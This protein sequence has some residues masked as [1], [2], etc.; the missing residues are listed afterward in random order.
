MEWQNKFETEKKRA[1]KVFGEI[2][3]GEDLANFE[4]EFLGK[5]SVLSLCNKNIKNLAPSEKQKWGREL[6]EFRQNWQQK[7][8]EKK[9]EIGSQSSDL[10]GGEWIDVSKNFPSRHGAVHP[11]QQVQRRTEQI[12]AGMGFEIADGPEVE[13]EWM[14]FDALNIPPSHPARDTQDTFFVKTKSDDTRQNSVL[15]THTSNAQVREMLRKKGPV[16]MICPGRA[17][18]SE[19][20]DATHDAQFYQFEGLLIDRNIN[21]CHLK[22]VCQ[23]FLSEFFEREIQIRIR[24]GYFPFVEPGIE[25]D[26]WFEPPGREGSWLEIMGAG[27]THP[28]V[29][30]NGGLDPD[31]FQGFAFGFGLTRIVM[32]RYEID[33]IRLLG[34]TQVEFLQNF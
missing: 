19:D 14:N 24:P 3:K 4:K 23:T 33:D 28:Q 9:T 17:F 7:I 22:A 5:S 25:I 16:R 8:E 13:T 2:K 21:L 18:R 20:V 12:F 29:I 27:M 34:S 1:N 6:Q 10:Q 31:V 26:M 11:L 15:R 30:A 32:I